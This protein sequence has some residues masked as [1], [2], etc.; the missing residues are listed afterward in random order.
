ML[1][2]KTGC[3][4]KDDEIFCTDMGSLEVYVPVT[5][6][7]IYYLAKGKEFKLPRIRLCSGEGVSPCKIG[8]IKRPN[9]VV[10]GNFR[11]WSSCFHAKCEAGQCGAS[12][13]T[14]NASLHAMERVSSFR[15]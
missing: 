11:F 1:W 3:Q 7:L 4:A 14:S 2:P 12:T 5:L 13:P 6:S 9:F 15:Q 10:H 8:T